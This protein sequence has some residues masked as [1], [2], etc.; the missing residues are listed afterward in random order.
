MHS[1]P[2]IIC[3]SRVSFSTSLGLIAIISFFV[4][5]T[6]SPLYI[7]PHWV[8]N[9][10][11]SLLL[12]YTLPSLLSEPVVFNHLFSA[13]ISL[14]DVVLGISCLSCD[15]SFY[16]KMCRKATLVFFPPPGCLMCFLMILPLW[17]LP[18]PLSL[19]LLVLSVFSSSIDMLSTG[20]I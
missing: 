4:S 16:P 15:F 2:I 12:L 7:V 8:I 17:R 18:L 6:Q 5:S 1:P 10:L 13:N 14:S 19:H 3:G 11:C 20:P 9:F